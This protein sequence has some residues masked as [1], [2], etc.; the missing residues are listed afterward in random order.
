LPPPNG[1]FEKNVE[2]EKEWE[3]VTKERMRS[4]N[5]LI[6]TLFYNKI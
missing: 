5:L 3:K 4:E 1:T 6:L 2:W